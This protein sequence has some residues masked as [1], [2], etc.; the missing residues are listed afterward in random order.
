V[1]VSRE[2]LAATGRG[3]RAIIC[4]AEGYWHG[5]LILID[6]TDGGASYH[7]QA[8]ADALRPARGVP[9]PGSDYSS[10]L[11]RERVRTEREK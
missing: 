2:R 8:L 5:D 6:P 10:A 9:V 7:S 1:E 3:D 4:G 11:A